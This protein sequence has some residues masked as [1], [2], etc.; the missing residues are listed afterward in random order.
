MFQTGNIKLTKTEESY[1]DR[2]S[3]HM[4]SKFR[5]LKRFHLHKYLLSMS[6]DLLCGLRQ[7]LNVYD[8]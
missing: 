8:L 5:I 4:A 2:G 3:Q 7:S 1:N 6:L